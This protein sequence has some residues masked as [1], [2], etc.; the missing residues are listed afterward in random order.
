[1]TAAPPPGIYHGVPFAEYLTWPYLSKS[2]LAEMAITPGH[3][4][5][6][7]D[8]PKERT[9]S[10][11]FGSA[12]DD[13]ISMGRHRFDVDYPQLP[14]SVEEMEAR[15]DFEDFVM[16][17]PGVKLTNKDGKAW[18]ADMEEAGL[19]V[20]KP[21]DFKAGPMS[22]GCGAAQA[23]KARQELAGRTV[24]SL[25]DRRRAI[26]CADA[27]TSHPRV[28]EMMA[29]ATMQASIVWDDPETGIRLKGRPDF[30]P[31]G[32]PV[33]DLKTT[34]KGGAKR[35]TFRST[36][37][38]LLYHWQA[39]MYCD[40]CTIATGETRNRFRFIAAE[41][42]GPYRVEVWEAPPAMLEQGRAGYRDA[43]RLY[44]ECTK[45]GDWPAST[46]EIRTIE[47]TKWQRERGY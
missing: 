2:L 23:W 27:I 29:G 8:H 41:T 33:D 37:F 43:L 35:S 34:K 9:A 28:A 16:A 44:A 6:R 47:F 25:A 32:T 31:D 22:S 40:G 36:I 11:V 46:N 7:R 15:A 4:A 38:D 18:R 24:L 30:L 17:P 20:T 5:W 10:M 3:L 19:I 14:R 21:A 26:A 13:L 12:V 42:E 45:S 39:A 1:M